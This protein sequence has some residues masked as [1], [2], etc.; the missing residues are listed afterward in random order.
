MGAPLDEAVVRVNT[1]MRTHGGGIEVVAAGEGCGDV[2]VRFTGMCCGCPW[3]ALTWTATVEP[4]LRAVP[5]V[6]TV[7]ASGV[8]ISEEAADR[9]AAYRAMAPGAPGVLPS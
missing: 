1:A 8:R 3:K 7:S 6:R 5:G 2:E 9:L 4:A